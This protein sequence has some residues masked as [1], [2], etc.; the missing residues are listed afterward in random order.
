[1]LPVIILV[2]LALLLIGAGAYLL[3]TRRGSTGIDL[4]P[5]PS[6]GVLAP[7]RPETPEAP[8]APVEPETIEAPPT[9][10]EIAPAPP[11][12]PTF[13]ERLA[14]A[15]SAFA[16]LLGRSKIDQETWDDLEE[17]LIRADLGIGP[18]MELVEDLRARVAAEGL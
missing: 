11:R 2:I 13:R 1:M 17:A 10:P 16:G 4:E 7:P 6:G 3:T 18:A 12:K 8:E 5:P 15:R 14:R 9:E